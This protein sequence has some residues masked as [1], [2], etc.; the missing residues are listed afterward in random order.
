LET[1][2][3]VIFMGVPITCVIRCCCNPRSASKA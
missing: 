3:L 1:F 2:D